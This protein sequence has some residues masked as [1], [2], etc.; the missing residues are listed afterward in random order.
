MA[1]TSGNTIQTIELNHE[2][3]KAAIN[4]GYWLRNAPFRGFENY[5]ICADNNGVVAN[6]QEFLMHFEPSNK[7]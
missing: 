2:A 4:C 1:T 5:E 7:V 6:S 3:T